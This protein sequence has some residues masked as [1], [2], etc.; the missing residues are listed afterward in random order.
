MGGKVREDRTIASISASRSS[1]LP[2][3]T[4]S[5]NRFGCDA[6]HSSQLIHS[7]SAARSAIRGNKLSFANVVL[8]EALTPHQ[9]CSH[10]VK[11]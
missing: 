3:I 9:L 6:R 11:D 4:L 7:E 10:Y 8:F 5:G 1:R 2:P